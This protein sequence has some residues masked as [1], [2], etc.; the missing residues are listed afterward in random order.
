MDGTTEFAGDDGCSSCSGHDEAEKY[1]LRQNRIGGEVYDAEIR[2]EAEGDLC[3]QYDP[4]PAMQAQVKGVHF[5]ESEEE[6][7]KDEPR[8]DGTQRQEPFIAEG[9]DEHR[10]PE[11]VGIKEFFEIQIK[12]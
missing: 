9:T 2:S 6:H 5:A 1:S 10:E 3:G 8:E 12:N 11:G 7:K 4:V